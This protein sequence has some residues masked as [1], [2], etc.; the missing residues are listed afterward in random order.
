[1]AAVAS[2][3]LYSTVEFCNRPQTSALT[4]KYPAATQNKMSVLRSRC[5]VLDA[6]VLHQRLAS[7]CKALPGLLAFCFPLLPAL[8]STAVR[9]ACLRPG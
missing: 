4:S 7:C 6:C 9:G 5:W 3:L 1:M 8:Q 2:M